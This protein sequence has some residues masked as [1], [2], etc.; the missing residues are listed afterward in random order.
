[1][2]FI[3]P[4][5]N[6]PKAPNNVFSLATP[7]H[8]LIKL[9]WEIRQFDRILKASNLSLIDEAW[10]PPFHAYNCAVTAWHCVDWAWNFGDQSIHESLARSL[11]FDLR[12]EN[13]A[14]RDAFCN[15]I[16]HANRD[17]HI[18]R[19]IANGSKHMKLDKADPGVRALVETRPVERADELFHIERQLFIDDGGH[20]RPAKE[21]FLGA[22]CYWERLFSEIGYIEGR[23]VSLDDE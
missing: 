4:L 19:Q 23:F 21:V 20:R 2:R 5:T 17:I 10:A 12:K 3:I 8:M 1:M 14:N 22:Y 18:C 9:G 6:L 13:R 15:A 11:R 7:Q 16:A